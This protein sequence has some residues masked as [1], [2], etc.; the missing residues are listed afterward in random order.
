MAIDRAEVAA[1][2]GPFVPDG[3]AVIVEIFDVGV[4][5]Q[6]PEQLV[7]DRLHVQLLGR[8]QRKALGEV[9]AHLMAEHRQR[10]GAG[11]IAL[12]RPVGDNPLHQ[13]VILMHACSLAIP[14]IRE[15][16]ALRAI[17]EIGL[18]TGQHAGDQSSRLASATSAATSSADAATASDGCA[19]SGAAKL[20]CRQIPI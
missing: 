11:A 4:A 6:E 10:A 16:S 19:I 1:L 2:V 7:D 8:D 13:V 3:D 15:F 14:G 12:L 9:E 17:L 18:P 20:W 5:S